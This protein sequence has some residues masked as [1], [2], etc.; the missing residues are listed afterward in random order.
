[1]AWRDQLRS[2]SFRGRKF[3]ISGGE[4][5]GGR[6]LASH[7]YPLRDEPYT[8]DMGRR[9]RRFTLEAYVLGQ[10]YFAARNALL[11]ACEQEGA[12]ELVH[13]YL[14]T[15]QVHCEAYRMRES[16]DEGGMA[17]FSLT[18]VEKGEQRFPSA[19]ASA[20][21][22]ISRKAISLSDIALAA[23]IRRIVTGGMPEF[24]RAALR[25]ALGDLADVLLSLMNNGRLQYTRDKAGINRAVNYRAAVTALPS[26][27]TNPT[28]LAQSLATTMADIRALSA[29]PAQAATSLAFVAD[30]FRVTTRE[31]T[32]SQIV[33]ENANKT[34]LK[35]YVDILAVANQAVAAQASAYETLE[36][37]LTARQDLYD[38]LDDLCDTDND[39]EYGALMT[40]RTETVNAIPDPAVSLPRLRSVTIATPLPALVLAYRLY[41]AIDMADDIVA[42]NRQRHPGF[43]QAGRPLE[44]LTDA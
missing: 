21:R 26:L 22:Q 41:G 20:A 10:D 13:P 18:F 38:R 6:R 43:L 2:A 14:G 8:E 35:R 40:L 11:K 25:L 29:T 42:R 37:A 16:S 33:I 24:V 3:F 44:V 30:S 9:I 15:L 7:E 4:N 34:A 1:M 17:R 28:L 27:T 39:D 31:A 19:V 12:G 5:E 23:F 36:A 32:T